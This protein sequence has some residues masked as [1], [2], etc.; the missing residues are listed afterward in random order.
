MRNGE[1]IPN[2]LE[3][4]DDYVKGIANAAWDDAAREAYIKEAEARPPQTVP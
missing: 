3:D 2:P 4:E 1:W